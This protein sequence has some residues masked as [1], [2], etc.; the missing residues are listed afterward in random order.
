MASPKLLIDDR[1]AWLE[2]RRSG[3]SATDIAGILGIHPYSSP[4]KVY[5]DKLGMSPEVEENDAMRFGTMME[6]LIAAEFTRQTGKEA[7][8][9]DF[10]RHAEFDHCICTPD[11]L[12]GEDELLECKYAGINT[13]KQFG[14]VGTDEV[15][16]QYLCQVQ[17][18]LFVTG[19]KV[20]YLMVCTPPNF[21][22]YT[23]PRDDE[24][25]RRMLFQAN[26]FWKEYVLRE[27]PPP[28]TGSDADTKAIDTQYPESNGEM[29]VA[30]YELEVPIADLALALERK[31]KEDAECD[32]LKNIIR[33]AMG[34]AETM[35]SDYGNFT[36]KNQDRKTVDIVALAKAKNIPTEWLEEFTKV[37][38]SRVF[39]TPYKT[40]KA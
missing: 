10:T 5:L 37:T 28:V 16:D 27:V 21:T 36:W 3:I 2:A 35:K 31:A 20:G 24:F 18:Q 4:R 29:I 11:Y 38:T 40:G 23:I 26:K 14:I 33:D 25:I 15:P 12:I 34:E 39:R 32:R 9:A 8:K 13:A 19:R 22:L 17:W 6:P 1:Q 7:T 30:S